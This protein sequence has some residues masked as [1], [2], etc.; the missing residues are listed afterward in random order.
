MI[1]NR[2]FAILFVT[3]SLMLLLLSM[4]VEIRSVRSQFTVPEFDYITPIVNAINMTEIKHDVEVFSNFG[5]RFTGYPGNLRAAEYVYQRFSEYLSDVEY[6]PFN[7]T[8]PVDEGAYVE[9][10]DYGKVT[11][12]PLLPNVV[13]PP[14]TPPG[15]ITA[16]L[17]YVGDGDLSNFDGKEVENSIVI[18][19]FNSLYHWITA[20]NLGAKAVIFIEPTDT[21]MY[22]AKRKVVSVAF[23]FPRLYV[24]AEDAPKLLTNLGKEVRLV[25]NMKIKTI[26]AYNVIGYLPGKTEKVILLTAHFDSFS[27]IPSVSPGARESIGMA[28][29]FQLAKFFSTHPDLHYYTLVFVGFSGTNQ[30]CQGSIWFV[31][32]MIQEKWDEWGKNVVFQMDIAISDGLPSLLPAVSG[33]LTTELS[34]SPW[35][36]GLRDWWFNVLRKDMS[37][38]MNMPELTADQYLD[39]TM[40]IEGIHTNLLATS[41]GSV[42][43]PHH[44]LNGKPIIYE[45]H[46]PLRALGG[47]SIGF[48]DYLSFHK[49]WGTPLDVSN[50]IHWNFVEYKMKIMY[51][52]ILATVNTDL[53]AKKIMWEPGVDWKP[54]IKVGGRGGWFRWPIWTDVEGEIV[55]YNY[56]TA[57][58][59]PVP[60]A[61]IAWRNA[62]GKSGAGGASGQ[63]YGM[64]MDLWLYAYAD[65]KGKVYLPCAVPGEFRAYVVNQTTGTVTYAPAFGLHAYPTEILQI[66]D[67]S[68]VTI[69]ANYLSFVGGTEFSFSKYTVQ[70][71]GSI[72]LFNVGDVY[73]RSTPLD[74]T[75]SM[76]PN[77]HISKSAVEDYSWHHWLDGG[78]GVGIA[79]LHVPADEPIDIYS[80]CTWTQKYPM[81]FWINASETNPEGSGFKVKVG[82]QVLVIHSDLQA[83]NDMFWLNN[84][85]L[86][87]L[88]RL[89]VPSP[90]AEEVYDL[91]GESNKAF[92]DREYSKSLILAQKALAK[93]RDLYMDT[94]LT[95]E[96]AGAAITFIGL[97][98]IPFTIL[99]ERL[100]FNSSS[101]KRVIAVLAL[102]V[103]PLTILW[104]FHPGFELSSNPSMVLVG[105]A[106]LVLLIPPTS[107]IGFLAIDAVNK[108]RTKTF[109]IHISELPKSSVAL[110][111]FSTGIKN[112]RKR[113]MRTG[114]ILAS[115]IIISSSSVI[116]TSLGAVPVIKPILLLHQGSYDGIFIRQWDWGGMIGSGYDVYSRGS[117]SYQIPPNVGERLYQE[118]KFTYGENATVVARAWDY[119]GAPVHHPMVTTNE[120]GIAFAKETHAILGLCPEE[121]GVTIDPSRD[122]IAGRWFTTLDNEE[123]RNVAIISSEMAA[124]FNITKEDVE[125]TNPPIV[126]YAGGFDYTV[127]GILNSTEFYKKAIDLDGLPIT[128]FDLKALPALDKM[129]PPEETIIIPFKT[130]TKDYQGFIC[131]VAIKFNNATED[132]ILNKVKDLYRSTR[133]YL[134][135]SYGGKVWSVS[136]LAEIN[137]MG[138]QYQITPLILAILTIMN[139]L[140]GSIYERL[141]EIKTY[142]IIGLSPLH[143]A[144]FFLAETLSYGV[145][146]AIIGY[147]VGVVGGYVANLV[148]IGIVLRYFGTQAINTILAIMG[149]IAL[150][151]VY[152]MIRTARLVTPSLERRWKLP[153]PVGNEWQI[154]LPFITESDREANGI[155]NYLL[156]FLDAHLVSDAEVFHCWNVNYTESEIKDRDVKVREIK[157]DCRIRPFELNI[158]QNAA[159]RLIK[160]L[161]TG[162]YS[163]EL[164]ITLTKGARSSWITFNRAFIDLFRKQFLIWR[165]F[166]PE[167]KEK[168]EKRNKT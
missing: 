134:W 3:L 65:E 142:G 25:S 136:K 22:E 147:V 93:A 45:D 151:S 35:A 123:R 135:A 73:Y 157:F 150:S 128:P 53:V 161:K 26:Q 149:G 34:D 102:Y 87:Q 119:L 2:G 20:A 52:L 129:V 17:I 114:L 167:E 148:N 46:E 125:S 145:V 90:A 143:L 138:W 38:K 4:N 70:P 33:G 152:P 67:K 99:A 163:T 101:L 37:V 141:N 71:V 159:I 82:G 111:S 18:M 95:I 122:L 62:I 57:W 11:L 100:F 1:R 155:I 5:T 98:I 47:P 103:I 121:A 48:I 69:K 168:Y 54:R 146:G 153:K 133:Y 164:F 106:V 84:P 83:A 94:R 127:I 51:P 28:I 109:G 21:S 12:Y 36:E 86:N 144:F 49:Y 42:H 110:I 88:Q 162:T 14:Q 113:P 78:Y 31:K 160:N 165:S 120:E 130:L 61:L 10:P 7:V 132:F 156:E 59:S 9:I 15:G 92:K 16:K 19:D 107:I 39:G 44:D 56:T 41:I 63:R 81:A 154:P 13:C 96:D 8:L 64:G 124:A 58:Y 89:G 60:N 43:V 104:P 80:K 40:K 117:T 32:E 118:L 139:L 140:L 108:M 137:V 77:S 97:V 30:G 55:Q 131:S 68:V 72:V 74:T 66:I 50:N 85:R 76:I 29:L 126:R 91:I 79:V 112:M 105:F 23:N 75:Y 27:W 158:Y 116:F 115:I 24:K 6:F 166:T